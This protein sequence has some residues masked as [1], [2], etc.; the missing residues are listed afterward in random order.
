MDFDYVWIDEDHHVLV[1]PEEE[2]L[3]R[4]DEVD[5]QGAEFER[6]MDFKIGAA[7]SIRQYG[8]VMEALKVLRAPKLQKKRR[9]RFRDEAL[10]SWD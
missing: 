10:L 3:E 5:V 7:T 2:E 6:N 1:Q 8:K 9:W 4:W